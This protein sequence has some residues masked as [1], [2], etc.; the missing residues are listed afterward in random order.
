MGPRLE[1]EVEYRDET[2]EIEV[3]QYKEVV[4]DVKDTTQEISLEEG[5]KEDPECEVGDSLG[6]KMDASAF[7]RIAA[8]SAKQVIMQRMKDAERDLVYED[9]KDRKGEIMNGIV[10]RVGPR[11]HHRQPGAD[12][13]PAAADG[14]GPPG[15]LPQGGTHPGVCPGREAPDPGTPDHFY[16]GRIPSSWWPCSD[17]EVPEIS[18]GIVQVLGCA[19]E[20]RQPFQD[21]RILPGLEDV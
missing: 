5:R 3:F 17:A 2:G 4:G 1:I 8:Q 11:G 20:A 9:Y 15:D 19:R 14:A 7:G 12:R 18:E 6:F 10:Q 21:C 13:G 16:P